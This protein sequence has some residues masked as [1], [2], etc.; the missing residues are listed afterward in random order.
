MAYLSIVKRKKYKKKEGNQMSKSV[1]FI[2]FPEKG[3]EVF[4]VPYKG[5][6]ISSVRISRYRLGLD[7]LPIGLFI[8]EDSHSNKESV[9]T[10]LPIN[11]IGELVFTT[12]DEAVAEL[13][14][15]KSA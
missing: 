1:K 13:E 15:R 10:Y 9:E 8:V 12:F 3:A 11:R 7:K 4:L 2:P 5:S 6:S 14:R